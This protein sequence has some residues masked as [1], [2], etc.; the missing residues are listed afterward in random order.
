MTDL[1][2]GEALGD[3]IRHHRKARRLSQS[4]VADALGRDQTLVSQNE[5]GARWVMSGAD[6]KTGARLNRWPTF[7]AWTVGSGDG[8][9]SKPST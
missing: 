6:S 8:N 2:L 9:S 7:G 4:A 3:L 5:K 1:S